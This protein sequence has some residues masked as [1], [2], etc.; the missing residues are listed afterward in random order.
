MTTLIMKLFVK[1]YPHIADETTRKKCGFCAG[2]VGIITNVMLVILKIIIG[3]ITNSVA[4]I[5][6]GVNN[7]GD[8]ASS[9]VTLIGFK[10]AGKQADDDHPFGHERIEYIAGLIVSL[11]IL[12]VGIQLIVQSVG[13]I[14]HPQKS[15]F[16]II[17]T[18]IFGS[19]LL[20][21]IWRGHFYYKVGKH[22]QSA[23]VSAAAQDAF[24][25]CISTTVVLISSIIMLFYPNI[26]IDG[27][28]GVIVSAFII[29]TGIDLIKE[30]A[31]P[32]IG[33]L[34]EQSLVD[35]I[36][37][38]AT[39]NPKILGYHDFMIHCY[40]P[41]R[42]FASIHLEFD[43]RENILEIHDI[44]DNV[45]S[46][47]KKQTGV[48]LVVHLDPIDMTD[49][50]TIKLK[51]QVS[52]IVSESENII[53]FHDF[54]VVKGPTHTNVLFDLVLSL[55]THNDIDAKKNIVRYITDQ[56][57]LINPKYNVIIKTDINL[58]YKRSNN[59]TH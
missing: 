6:E 37:T 25:D 51:E 39:A 28:A 1:D 3:T 31:D 21:K 46:E 9:V 57:R 32:L 35:S 44:A 14:L 23:T 20:I 42:M 8:A 13:K 48:N 18:V 17:T 12:I 54:R 55:D 19:S 5:A 47:T 41:S 2:V 7:L 11:L 33:S 53:S 16:T 22:I 29:K 56:I 34:P 59:E 58:V 40:G 36:I 4:I 50:E 26:H 38:I 43:Y 15:D 10:L 49:P 45:E 24:N 27:Y 52:R 30:T